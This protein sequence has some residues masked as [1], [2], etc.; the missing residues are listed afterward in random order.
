MKYEA[1][2]FSDRWDLSASALD[3]AIEEVIDYIRE[4]K[5][6]FGRPLTEKELAMAV[7]ESSVGADVI[8][9]H[10]GEGDEILAE[11]SFHTEAVT[12]W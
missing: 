12:R 6:A 4:R 11:V 2:D 7:A 3:D 10:P 8:Q 5:E 9:I 1:S